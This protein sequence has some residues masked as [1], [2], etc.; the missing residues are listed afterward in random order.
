MSDHDTCNHAE[1]GGRRPIP[2]R[3]DDTPLASRGISAAPAGIRSASA[4][5]PRALDREELKL[6]A[7]WL[8]R[9]LVRRFVKERDKIALEGVS[10][11]GL[12]VLGTI[13]REGEQRL[14]EL[15]ER[16]DFTSGAVT[17][18]CD[19][20]ESA[21]YAERRRSPSDRR[22]VALGITP[23]GRELL[24]RTRSAGAYTVELLFGGLEPA[25][26]ESR[27]GLFRELLQRLDGFAE[28]VTERHEQSVAMPV[29]MPA[30]LQAVAEPAAVP[31]AAAA[32][33]P[34]DP[35]PPAKPAAPQRR[36]PFIHY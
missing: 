9:K 13:R 19:K 14:G 25:E 35:D 20:L 23:A 24:E 6:E 34:H 11:P 16:L 17:A 4:D 29:A 31:E 8:F 15:A 1:G 22:S 21:G 10:L 12:L 32:P 3:E 36:S 26:L 5:S 27:I 18:L 28:R 33:D 2:D 30:P 7:D